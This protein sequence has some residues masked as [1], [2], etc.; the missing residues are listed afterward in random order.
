M[1]EKEFKMELKPLDPKQIDDSCIRD[2]AAAICIEAAVEYRK[3]ICGKYGGV[4]GKDERG[5]SIYKPYK[6][7]NTFLLRGEKGWQP[8][9][10][11]HIDPPEEYERFFEG[12][13]FKE[14]SGLYDSKKVIM[15]LR[16][17]RGRKVRA[18]W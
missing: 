10:I 4:V 7:G 9:S 1:K 16:S 13:W 15:F 11:Q 12:A 8:A 3:A 17:V 2:L 5:K 18:K 6:G 14:L